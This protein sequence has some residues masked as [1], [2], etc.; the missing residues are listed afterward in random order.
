MSG[1]QILDIACTQLGMKI[2]AQP[3]R[4]QP[5]ST[6]IG[7][8]LPG[9]IRNR[10]EYGFLKNNPKLDPDITQLKLQKNPYIY[11]EL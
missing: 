1:R 7:R 4:T 3:T 8:V 6:L 9:P 2:F 10:I 11:I 5:G